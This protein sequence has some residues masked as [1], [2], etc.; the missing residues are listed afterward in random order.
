MPGV[1]LV[2]H[3]SGIRAIFSGNY[4]ASVSY[5]IFICSENQ[6]WPFLAFFLMAFGFWLAFS[7][8][9]LAPSASGFWLV[10][11]G[12]WL[13]V[14]FLGDLLFL[15]FKDFFLCFSLG[16]LPLLFAAFWSQNL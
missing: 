12:F 15:I 11:C 1:S 8:W 5:D 9:L 4:L 16:Q 10:A 13:R 2:P 3:I 7:F 6:T 14:Y